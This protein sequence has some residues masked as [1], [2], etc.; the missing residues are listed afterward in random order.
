[1][2][3]RLPITGFDSAKDLSRINLYAPVLA[4]FASGLVAA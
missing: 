2:T 4:A 3:E 1:V